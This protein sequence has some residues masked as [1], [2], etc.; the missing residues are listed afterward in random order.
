MVGDRV[1]G[2]ERER[3]REREVERE[4]FP[5]NIAINNILKKIFP[6]LSERLHW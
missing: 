1:I 5:K 4:R 3:D 2:R 6:F